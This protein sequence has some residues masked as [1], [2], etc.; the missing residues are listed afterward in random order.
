[1]SQ[2]IEV[3]LNHSLGREEALR[4]IADNLGN[5]HEHMPGQVAEVHERWEGDTLHLTIGAM[6][7]EVLAAIDVEEA[8]VHL[9]VELPGIL[10]MFAQPI[11]AALNSR[12]NELLLEDR[13]DDD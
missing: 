11:A 10:A 4:R 12:G 5:L 9:K 13:H 8:K 3:D 2:P 6:G 1:M 7:Q